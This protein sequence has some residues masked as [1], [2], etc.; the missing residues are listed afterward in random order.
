M[1]GISGI[2][3]KEKLSPELKAAVSRMS[4]AQIHRGP[5]G[6]GEFSSDN[7]ALGMRRLSIIDPNGG[8]Q[9]LYNEDKSLALIINGEIYNYIEL[10]ERL[11]ASGH[12]FRTDADG[13]VI[14]HLYEE[15]DADFISH[16][17]GMFAFALWDEKRRRLILARDRMGEKPLYLYERDGELFFASELKGL[18]RSNFVPFELDA[19][20]VNLYFYYQYVPEP[21]TAVKNVRKL[22][23][24]RMLILDV[25]NWRITEKT[26]WKMED[27]PPIEGEPRDVI[28]EKLEEVSKLIVRS[29]MPV[30]VALSGGLDSSIVAAFAAKQQPNLHAF[31][32]GYT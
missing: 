14:L 18:L 32:V 29:D 7:I 23:A 21:L 28:R 20:A 10:R 25:E 16:L 24:A 27:A 4:A 17:R 2:I 19:R 31:S 8:W 12:R 26:Y 1:C 5:D 3:T 11:K 30:G 9:P 22:D 6:A 15:N 13:E